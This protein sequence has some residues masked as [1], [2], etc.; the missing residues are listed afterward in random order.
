[1]CLD[2]RSRRFSLL[3]SLLSEGFGVSVR[4]CSFLSKAI[5]LALKCSLVSPGFGLIMNTGFFI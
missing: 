2:E 5:S 4:G 1:M 3:F